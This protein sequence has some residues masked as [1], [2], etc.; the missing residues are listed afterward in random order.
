MADAQ[1]FTQA[2]LDSIVEG[3]LARERPKYADCEEQKLLV[4]ISGCRSHPAGLQQDMVE[5]HM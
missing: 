1:T 2:E 4:T 3:R 5:K